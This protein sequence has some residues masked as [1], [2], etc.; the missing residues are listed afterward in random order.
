MRYLLETGQFRVA[1][2]GKILL[3]P[4]LKPIAPPDEVDEDEADALE[5]LSR[6]ESSIAHA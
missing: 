6:L 2:N 4:D 5:I 1:P 3:P